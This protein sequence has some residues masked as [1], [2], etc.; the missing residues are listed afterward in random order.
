MKISLMFD[1]AKK[2]QTKEVRERK[3]KETLIKV[4]H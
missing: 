1:L 2:E 4:I 3:V